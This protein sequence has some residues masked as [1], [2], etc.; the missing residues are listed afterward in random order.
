MKSI[1]PSKVIS[2]ICYGISV[3]IFLAIDLC[4][5]FLHPGNEMGYCVL[6]FYMIM[7][8]TSLIVSLIISMKRGYLFWFYPI[9]VGL[10]GLVIPFLVFGT[11]N[12]ADLFF[13]FFP[14]LVGLAIGLI[15]RFIK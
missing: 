11:F 10:C 4:G 3:F 5:I 14:A 13:A 1:N 7:P 9:F 2:I 8:F 6:F 12:V 15:I